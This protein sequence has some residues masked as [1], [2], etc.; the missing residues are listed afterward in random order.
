VLFAAPCAACGELLDRPLRGPVCA[1]CWGS[2]AP[3]PS[4]V[5]AA[6]EYAG[7]L[8]AIIHALKYDGRRSLA[9]PLAALMRERGARVLAGAD[10]AVAVPL[11]AARRRERGFNQAHDLAKRLG[12]PVVPALMRVRATA[13]QALLP[14]DARPA[15]VA[16]AFA[17]TRHARRL[18]GRVVV[19]VDD[20]ATTGATLEACASVLRDGGAAEVR[21]LTAARVSAPPR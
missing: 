5:H 20:V 15:N 9:G 19:L 1:G 12:L 4:G 14:A 6:G 18:R 11:H 8:K 7:P 16:G 21:V 3:A 17:A 2:I 13:A 10:A